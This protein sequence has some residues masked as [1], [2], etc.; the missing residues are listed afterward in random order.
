MFHCVATLEAYVMWGSMWLCCCRFG[1]KTVEIGELNNTNPWLMPVHVV[2]VY[3]CS[4]ASD[5]L[6]S[7]LPVHAYS[8]NHAAY[9]HY[10]YR[11]LALMILTEYIHLFQKK[12]H[13]SQHFPLTG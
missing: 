10:L 8:V 9:F 12:I 5:G 2:Q 13:A 6:L 1:P 4:G 11:N 7:F 3:I